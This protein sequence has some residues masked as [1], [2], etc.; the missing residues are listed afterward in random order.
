MS[1]LNIVAITGRFTRDPEIKKINEKSLA[2][3]SLAVSKGKEE[4]SYFDCTAWEKT[5]ELIQKYCKK[6]KQVNITGEL[7]QER[8]ERDGQ[9]FN[10][11]CIVVKT[12]QLTGSRSNEGST[13]E[14]APPQYK[15][16]TA[17]K[18][19]PASKDSDEDDIF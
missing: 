15:E 1:D 10:K 19:E 5:A 3:F 16:K 12:I 9:K 8:W 4:V 18:P 2:N 6:G 13:Q 17:S 14:Y 11:V 7:K